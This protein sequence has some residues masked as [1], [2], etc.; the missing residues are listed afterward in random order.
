MRKHLLGILAGVLASLLGAMSYSSG[1]YY[2]GKADAYLD[3]MRGN[4]QTRAFG[5]LGAN[6]LRDL[7]ARKYGVGQEVVAGCV[8]THEGA[9]EARG[10]NEVM[11]AAVEGRFG[12]DIFSVTR[13]EAELAA[14]GELNPQSPR[15]VK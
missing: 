2:D 10:Y 9:E 6:P 7:L 5:H 15:P 3:L 11:E 8:V 13:L 12:K 14:E 1:A 4:Y